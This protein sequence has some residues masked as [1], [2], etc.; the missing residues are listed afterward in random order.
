MGENLGYRAELLGR[1]GSSGVS[2]GED[3]DGSR[4]R[5]RTVT[6]VE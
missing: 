3:G 5:A 1:D 2:E 6:A 4:V